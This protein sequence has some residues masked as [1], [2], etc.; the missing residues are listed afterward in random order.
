LNEGTV[1]STTACNACTNATSM[2]TIYSTAAQSSKAFMYLGY[3]EWG[4]GLSTAGTYAS[5]PTAI[6]TMGV[7]IRK[8]GE[9]IGNIL[10]ASTSSANTATSS[11]FGTGAAPA[12]AA[13][14][15][16]T[17]TMSSNLIKVIFTGQEATAAAGSSS[18]LCAIFQG[19]SG[20]VNTQVGI[21]YGI[22]NAAVVPLAGPLSTFAYDAPGVTTAIQYTERVKSQDNATTVSCPGST[23]GVTG[24]LG[25][26]TVEEIMG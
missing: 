10:Q 20:S 5:G 23:G 16:I 13:T 21:I 2:G 9:S 1:L 12:N 8:P 11:S 3:L 22:A 24:V 18:A 17:P 7:G 4:S 25:I 26:I 14:V 6:Q 19:A 15:T